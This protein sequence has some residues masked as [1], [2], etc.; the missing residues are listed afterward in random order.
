MVLQSADRNGGGGRTSIEDTISR[1]QH[2]LLPREI[3][4]VFYGTSVTSS[5]VKS[6][7]D[8][9]KRVCCIYGDKS[10]PYTILHSSSYRTVLNKHLLGRAKPRIIT[11][12]TAEN[13]E[14]CRHL[15]GSAE[16]RHLDSV[17]C[18]FALNECEFMGMS[19]LRNGFATEMVYSNVVEL[20]E[21]QRC[22][23]DTLWNNST[24]VDESVIGEL[25]QQQ[26]R[27]IV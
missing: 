15:L 17:T 4:R 10:L 6:F 22:L 23:F 13:I 2:S 14:F 11:E 7:F 25:L 5:L 20:V 24:A 1:V 19:Q 27:E 16:L 26:K 8:R 9:S 18:N 12:V 3:T 21:Q